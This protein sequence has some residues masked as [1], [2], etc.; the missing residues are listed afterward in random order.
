MLV[1]EA[2]QIQ[3]LKLYSTHCLDLEQRLCQGAV[4][5]CSSATNCPA[6]FADP[7]RMANTSLNGLMLGA[8]CQFV[9]GMVPAYSKE[10]V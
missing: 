3:V 10:K 9:G 6:S 7:K 8:V 4:P 5:D 1:Y 2:E